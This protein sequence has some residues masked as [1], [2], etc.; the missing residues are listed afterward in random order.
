MRRET[1]R[2]IDP[3]GWM[4]T[5]DLGRL[6]IDGRVVNWWDALRDMIIRGGENI[7]PV[8]RKS[9]CV[10]I[11]RSLKLQSSALPDKFYGK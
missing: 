9:C 7:Y 11:R 6:N 1:A 5:G 2:C 8:D 10:S 4:N 3:Q